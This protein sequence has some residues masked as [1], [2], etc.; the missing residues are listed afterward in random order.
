MNWSFSLGRVSN[1]DIRVHFTFF[2]ILLFGA[3]QW[4][5]SLG[6]G[7]AALFGV[8]VTTLLFVCVLLHE[9]GHSLV[10]QRLDIPVKQILL[11]PLGGVALLGR[12]PDKPK[13]ELVIAA[14]GPLV[15]VAII[16]ALLVLMPLLGI[17]MPSL[18]SGRPAPGLDT[19]VWWMLLANVSL[20]LFNLIPAFPLDGGRMFRALLA[21]RIGHARATQIASRVGQLLAVGLGFVGLFTTNFLLILVAA[22]VF[23]GASAETAE[24]KAREILS[25]VK[26]RDAANRYAVTLSA[27]DRLSQVMPLMMA[28]HQTSFAVMFNGQVMGVVSEADLRRAVTA[29]TGDAYIAGIMQRE[30]LRVDAEQTLYEVRNTLAENNSPVAAVYEGETYLGLVTFS[31]IQE[32][33]RLWLTSKPRQ[34]GSPSQPSGT[35]VGR[36]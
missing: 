32:I 2:F 18:A 24:A 20:V 7:Q 31:G 13:H 36:V 6:N 27:G 3:L 19:L 9:L 23:F 34:A 28:T 10:A 14:A 35:V 8:L 1:I 15:N 33:L 12:N 30:F 11:M 26:A 16:A 21:M 25:R 5:G 29:G 22:F 4:G 17:D